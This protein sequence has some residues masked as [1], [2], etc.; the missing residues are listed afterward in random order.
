[1]T[2]DYILIGAGGTGSF[3]FPALIRYLETHARATEEQFRI[4]ILDGKEVSA[5][6]LERQLFFGQYAGSN[7]A[8]ALRDQY[9]ADPKVVIAMPTY[10]G[11][12][13]IAGIREGAVVL[14]AADNFPTRARIEARAREMDNVTI[15]NGG[16]EM[17]DGSMQIYLRRNATDITPPLS[18]GHPEILRDDKADPSRLSCQQIA[19]LPSGEQLIIA[20]MM[21]AATMLNALRK[22]HDWETNP[23]PIHPLAEEVFFD[24]ET[25]GMR[26]V[27]RPEPL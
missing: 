25:F 11:D 6:K 1:M 22:I 18:Q 10:L 16:N 26:A 24:L 4:T 13:N 7:K 15:I 20:N 21:S 5:S 8:E 27:A 17:V 3:L 19:E 14:I 2:R 23:E 9:M 12:D